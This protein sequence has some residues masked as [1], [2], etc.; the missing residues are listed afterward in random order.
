ML[1]DLL[2]AVA[3]QADLGWNSGVAGL[4]CLVYT[5]RGYFSQEAVSL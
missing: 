2:E 3:F 1:G 5:A 4:V